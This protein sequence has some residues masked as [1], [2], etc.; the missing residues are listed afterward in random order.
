MTIL[1]KLCMAQRGSWP[2]GYP[3]VAE[4]VDTKSCL[5]QQSMDTHKKV[6]CNL[7]CPSWIKGHK[8]G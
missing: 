1:M 2:L 3:K 5:I 8:Q 6:A 7:N 4:L